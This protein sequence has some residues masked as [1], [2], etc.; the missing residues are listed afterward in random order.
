LHDELKSSNEERVIHNDTCDASPLH[1]KKLEIIDDR[2]IEQFFAQALKGRIKRELGIIIFDLFMNDSKNWYRAKIRK[3][4]KE[5]FDEVRIN[6][7]NYFKTSS[8]EARCTLEDI[9]NEQDSPISLEDEE[10]FTQIEG[11]FFGNNSEF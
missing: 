9:L 11:E 6:G 8:V 4:L 10:L 5:G 1:I 2:I 7:Y 3:T